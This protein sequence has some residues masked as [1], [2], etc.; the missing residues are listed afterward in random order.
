[1]VQAPQNSRLLK[2]SMWVNVL[3]FHHCKYA[4]KYTL[5][6]IFKK[7]RQHC[8]S[9]ETYFCN[10]VI[11]SR[12]GLLSDNLPFLSYDF[13]SFSIP[14]YHLKFSLSLALYHSLCLTL[15]PFRSSCHFTLHYFF[16]LHL[17]LT[18]M[19]VSFSLSVY[20]SL[21]CSMFELSSHTYS[22]ALVRDWR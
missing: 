11:C 3:T 20:L 21:Y 16:L 17:N 2:Y 1:M 19:P 8:A 12:H 9:L 10:F 5:K 13:F 18:T 4:V 14:S 15:V 22:T 6:L 7:S